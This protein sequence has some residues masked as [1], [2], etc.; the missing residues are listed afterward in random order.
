MNVWWDFNDQVY[1]YTILK[2]TILKKLNDT[3]NKNL[4]FVDSLAEAWQLVEVDLNL[5]LVVRKLV[6]LYERGIVLLPV[7]FS[8]DSNTG[9]SFVPLH[10]SSH[11]VSFSE[12]RNENVFAIPFT[13]VSCQKSP[14]RVDIFDLSEWHSFFLFSALC[15]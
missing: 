9:F 13:E 5:R 1:K 11:C 2:H 10:E 14:N 12:E 4:P 6:L 15:F 8:G 3:A 7:N